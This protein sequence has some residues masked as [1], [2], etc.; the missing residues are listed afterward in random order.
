MNNLIQ[1]LN[2][3]YLDLDQLLTD[4]DEVLAN[5]VEIETYWDDET[6]RHSGT[7]DTYDEDGIDELRKIYYRLEKIL[8]D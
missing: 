7:I 1:K 6:G 3:K 5:T 4:F 8:E 2:D